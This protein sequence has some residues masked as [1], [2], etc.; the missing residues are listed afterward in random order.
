MVSTIEVAR[1]GVTVETVGYLAW[2]AFEKPGVLV[3]GDTVQ[4]NGDVLGEVCGFDETHAP[5]HLNIVVRT[6]KLLTG[7]TANFHPDTRVTFVGQSRE[8]LGW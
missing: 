4:V 2:V 1:P 7:R 6:P 3:A 5:N 8:S